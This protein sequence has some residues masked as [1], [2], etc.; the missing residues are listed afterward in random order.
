MPLAFLFLYI[1]ELYWFFQ[2][3]MLPALLFE[4]CMEK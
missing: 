1:K 3:G 4:K 2:V